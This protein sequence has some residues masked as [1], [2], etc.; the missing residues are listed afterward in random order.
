MTTI[1]VGI[2]NKTVAYYVCKME[3]RKAKRTGILDLGATSG[4]TP[5]EDMINLEDTG[6]MSKK[7]FM[8]LDKQTSMAT[9]RML[10]KHKI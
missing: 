10:L 7:M 1:S 6:K 8:S 3:I 2:K 4:A 9:K 5:E